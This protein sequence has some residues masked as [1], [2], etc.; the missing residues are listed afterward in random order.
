[1]RLCVCVC[2]VTAYRVSKNDLGPLSL[3]TAPPR[4]RD[5]FSS[6][7]REPPDG[8]RTGP[9][10]E[11]ESRSRTG[12]GGFRCPAPRQAYPTAVALGVRVVRAR[13]KRK[14]L[15]TRAGSARVHTSP[16]GPT[17]TVE[18]TRLTTVINEAHTHTHP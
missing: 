13:G 11:P 7:V 12:A 16:V 10:L 5:G 17:D 18:H 1:M 15:D 4:R 9:V 8:S 3:A 14:G 6:P 2:A